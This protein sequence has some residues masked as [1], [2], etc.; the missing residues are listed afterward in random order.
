M[1]DVEKFLKEGSATLEIGKQ[2]KNA[3]IWLGENFNQEEIVELIATDK[4]VY[5]LNDKFEKLGEE[6]GMGGVQEV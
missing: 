5:E 1:I 2:F 3:L 4:D 6:L